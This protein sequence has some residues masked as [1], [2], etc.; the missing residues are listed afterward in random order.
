[1]QL[2]ILYLVYFVLK[3]TDI[4]LKGQERKLVY[5]AKKTKLQDYL[6]IGSILLFQ[7]QV[8]RQISKHRCS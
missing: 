5:T 2:A 1:M 7:R 3:E 6:S 4:H 8:R